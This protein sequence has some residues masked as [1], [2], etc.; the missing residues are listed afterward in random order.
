M[1]KFRIT[2]TIKDTDGEKRR[3]E[4]IINAKSSIEAMNKIREALAEM[5][6]KD[7]TIVSSNEVVE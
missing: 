5:N 3:G 4:T 7:I 6:I 2:F 1:K